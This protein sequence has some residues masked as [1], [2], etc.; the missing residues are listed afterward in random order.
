MLYTDVKHFQKEI[1]EL[2]KLGV[3]DPVWSRNILIFERYHE[4]K[5]QKVCNYCAYEFIAEEE[6]LSWS[7]VKQ[8]VKKFSERII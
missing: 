2:T 8:I 3:V 4:L 7:S 5:G 1:K 6:G